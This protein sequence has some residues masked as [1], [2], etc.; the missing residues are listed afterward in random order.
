MATNHE[1]SPDTKGKGYG[2]EICRAKSRL[3]MFPKP[4][5]RRPLLMEPEEGVVEKKQQMLQESPLDAVSSL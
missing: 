1:T 2:R 3:K 5:V 4:I